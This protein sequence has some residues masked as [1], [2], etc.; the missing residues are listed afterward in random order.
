M[1]PAQILSDWSG[2]D[3][4]ERSEKL[5]YGIPDGY[6]ESTAGMLNS[7]SVDK[8]LEIANQYGLQMRGHDAVASAGH[9]RVSSRKD[10]AGAALKVSNTS[11][12]QTT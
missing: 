3:F 11:D 4:C 5:G 2:Y 7:D 9:Q 8:I 6:T 1:K 10:I 12:G